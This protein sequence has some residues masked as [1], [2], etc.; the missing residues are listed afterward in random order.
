MSARQQE[1]NV[2]TMLELINT[3]LTEADRAAVLRLRN[4]RSG[5][6]RR[7]APDWRKDPLAWAAWQGLRT[8]LGWH[9]E[10]ATFKLLMISEE[11]RSTW[12]R[13]SSAAFEARRALATQQ[14]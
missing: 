11:A 14:A 3:H 6:V 2:A 7:T 9:G 13:V 5:G 4:K 10:G 8:A 12:D 1:I